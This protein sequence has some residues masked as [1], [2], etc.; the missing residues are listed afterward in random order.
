M[1]RRIH[2]RRPWIPE[3]VI[4]IRG[5]ILEPEAFH[6]TV[7][8]DHIGLPVVNEVLLLLPVGASARHRSVHKK[9]G[10]GRVD[11]SGGAETGVNRLTIAVLCWA[12]QV[13]V[14]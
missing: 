6:V 13:V 11:H 7:E 9:G 1:L 10:G 14:H 12:D 8:K 4:P 5:D 2:I 3:R